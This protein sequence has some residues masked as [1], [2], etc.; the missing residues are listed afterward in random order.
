MLAICALDLL[1]SP[2]NPDALNKLY[3]DICDAEAQGHTHLALTDFNH[4]GLG[5]LYIYI[6][7]AFTLEKGDYR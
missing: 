3:K 1:L 5:C 4:L 7:I 6:Y 2:L